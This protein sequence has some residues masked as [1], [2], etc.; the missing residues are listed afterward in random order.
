MNDAVTW[1]DR[2]ADQVIE[3]AGTRRVVCAS[4]I[5]PSGPIHLGNLREVATTHLVAEALLRR[6][7]DA[8]H[9]HSWDD[10]DRLRRVPA[11]VE[12][13][14]EQYVGMPLAAVPD[15]WGAADSY[16]DHF[17]DEFTGAMTRLGI[18]LH[19]VRQSVEYPSGRYN[20]A[21]RRAMDQRE[22]VFDL[23]TEQQAGGR[24]DSGAEERRRDY[25]PF[26]PYCEACGKDDTRVRSYDG[27][28]V[29]YECRCG[30]RGQLSLADGAKISG[31][32]VWRVDWPMRWAHERV[33]F[34]PAGEDHHAPTGSFAGGATLIRAL[35]GVEPPQS[36]VYSFVTLAGANGKMSGSAGG[37]AIPATA[38]DV[39]EPALVRWL[40][41]RRLPAQSFA[42]DLAPQP[43]QRLYDEWDRLTG[44]LA[45]PDP[46]P[47][48]AAVRAYCV[49]TAEGPVTGTA[50]P[51][52]FRLLGSA[53]DLTGANRTQIARI[54]REH[55]PADERPGS[56]GR[57]LAE[58]EPRL[59][60]AVNWATVLL[61]EDER[62]RVAD[63]FDR[64]AWDRLDDDARD[65]L[66]RLAAGLDGARDLDELT[67]LVYGV[68][69][70]LLGLPDDALPTPELKKAQRAFFV[71]VYRQLCGRDTGPRI[72]TLLLSIGLPRAR[73]LLVPPGQ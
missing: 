24:N 44:T 38:L 13:S 18:G 47:T 6:G 73:G 14:F 70:Q 30:H 29:A 3:Q 60:C 62:T 16:A 31:K 46:D 39:L 35:Y 56:D 71:A 59:T 7:V 10:Y 53:A 23:I 22:L 40:Y 15:P 32:L 2:L 5:S 52:S 4:G 49:E 61:P 33:A 63:R 26:K 43:V 37:A 50:R 28:A 68:P 1:M 64:D 69:K 48:E 41:A 20:A 58:L 67:A 21:I 9:L 55:L 51:V 72:P 19:E 65:G 45:G 8:V 42:I 57:L 36:T 17:I 25:Y 12:P 34:E 66:G 54:V 27:E 11:G